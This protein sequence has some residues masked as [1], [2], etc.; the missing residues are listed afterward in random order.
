MTRWL[1]TAP[2]PLFSAYCIVAAFGAYFCMYAF[3]K[4]FTAGTFA[5]EALFGVDYKT[6]L[7]ISQV[8]GYTISKFVGI[9]VIAEL[10]AT[11]RAVGIVAL[12]AAAHAALLLFALTP[13]PY[14]FALLFLNGL[15]LGMVF[16][17]VLS[18]L[19]GRRMTEL[20]SAGLCASFIM[21]SGYVKSVGQAIVLNTSIGEYWMPFATGLVFW[22]PLLACVW[23]LAHVPPPGEL[24][25]AARSERAPINA[26]ERR[27][28]LRKYGFGLAALITI[29][30]LLTILRSL[31]DD[32]A[33]EIWA[34]LGYTET[35]SVFAISETLV[36][37]AVIAVNGV[38]F[39]IK[40]N[41]AAFF[42]AL[43]TITFG[44]LLIAATT[45]LYLAG[46]I[47]G[48]S[49]MVVMGIGAYVPY[50]AFHTTLFERMI[51]LFRDKA[52][53]GYL[54]YLADAIGYLGYVAVLLLRNFATVDVDF[55]R[56]MTLTAAVISVC[57]LLAVAAAAIYFRRMDRERASEHGKHSL[58][59]SSG[60]ASAQIETA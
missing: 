40:S 25:V 8:I 20:L 32:F 2:A 31:R 39:L 26:Q 5:D 16:G 28:I 56:A 35:P 30:T 11:R 53:I 58:A 51:A 38:A 37:A 10:P 6:V 59:P 44:V 54:M 22:P 45:I 23:M 14:N 21:S 46:A 34:G 7:V 41:R 13:R 17:L 4:P 57:S 52:N 36:M 60:V 42:T 29:Y 47:N 19:E 1:S 3:R 9:R 43:H 18:F 12:I 49:Y 50:V 33:V 15:P 24:D 27:G 55:L 48:F